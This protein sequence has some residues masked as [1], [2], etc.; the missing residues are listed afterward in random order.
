MEFAALIYFIDVI[1]GEHRDL[2]LVVGFGLLALFL[3][4]VICAVENKP[5]FYK[6]LWP[7]KVFLF[8]S[9]PLIFFIPNKDT[10]Y[11]MLAAYEVQSIIENPEV[12]KL[13]GKS[14]DV[15]NKAMDEY[16]QERKSVTPVSP[17][18][19]ER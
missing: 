19:V 1:C 18:K 2:A 7:L 6:S 12:Q 15:L 14:L 17:E 16:L 11:K 13:G 5:E 3:A 9:I 8:V 10:A 4:K